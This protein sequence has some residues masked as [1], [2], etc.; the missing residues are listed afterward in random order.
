MVAT[1]RRYLDQLAISSRPSTVAATSDALRFFAGQTTRDDPGLVS[2][3]QL[4]RR[5]IEAHKTWMAA[6]PGKKGKPISP[7]TICHRLGFLRTFFE[8][9]IEWGYDDAPDRQ[10]VFPG[11]FPERDEPLP[12]FLDD[13]TAAKFMA[14]LAADPNKRRRL[15]VELLARTGM[16]A[17]ELGALEAALRGF[18]WARCTNWCSLVLG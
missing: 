4:E 10:L 16:R 15:I 1:I 8:R 14:A 3:A 17:G 11:D 2:I 18:A 5:H 9:L 6:R 7:V 13:P 12:K